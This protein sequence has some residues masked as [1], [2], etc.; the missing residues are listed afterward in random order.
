MAHEL[1]FSNGRAN[2]AYVGQTPWHGLGER[3]PDG[4]TPAEMRHAA[5]LDWS[6]IKTPVRFVYGAEL[7]TAQDRFCVVRDD[8]GVALGTVSDRY[9]PVQPAEV[10][11]FF[12]TLVDDIGGYSLETAGSLYGGRRIW[13]MAR[14]GEEAEVTFADPVAPYLLLATSFDGTLATTAQFTAVRVVCNNTL[15]L[16]MTGGPAV[17]QAVQVRH[18]SVFDPTAMRSAL[19]IAGRSFDAMIGD[20][21]MLANRWMS[22]VDARDFLIDLCEPADADKFLSTRTFKQLMAGFMHQNIGHDGSR[23]AWQMLNTVT[24]RTDWAAGRSQDAR[25]QSAW[26]GPGAQLKKRAYDLLVAA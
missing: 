5:G 12:R 16:S 14:V 7:R 20:M 26:F 1:D 9:V 2:M 10:F 3:L 18:N 22:P 13:A 6:V 23:T 11:D 24:E 25:L 21:Q 19:G 8:T 15:Q 17:G 4:A